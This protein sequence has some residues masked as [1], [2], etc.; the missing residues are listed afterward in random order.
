MGHKTPKTNV[1]AQTPQEGSV[2]EPTPPKPTKPPKVLQKPEPTPFARQGVRV[3]YARTRR[4]ASHHRR[5]DDQ[6]GSTGAQEAIGPSHGDGAT[7]VDAG[8]DTATDMW[9]PSDAGAEVLYKSAERYLATEP[10][11]GLSPSGAGPEAQEP[12]AGSLSEAPKRR[13][14]PSDAG[15]PSASAATASSRTER[16][17]GAKEE[18]DQGGLSLFSFLPDAANA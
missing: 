12:D 11:R 13:R 14:A 2:A 18:E 15:A 3:G 7:A 5:R 4:Q 10:K 1:K 8:D 9:A 17:G 16:Q 6:P